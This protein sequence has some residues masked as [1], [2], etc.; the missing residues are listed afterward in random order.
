MLVKKTNTY[1]AGFTL[2]E[3]LV[4]IFIIGILAALLLANFVGVRERTTDAKIK[5]DLRAL[6]TALRL[7]YNDYN[8]YPDVTDVP[9][10]GSETAFTNDDEST[11]YMKQVPAEFSYNVSADGEEFLLYAALDNL[12]DEDVAESRARCCAGSLACPDEAGNY[13]I[14]CED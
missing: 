14:I 12:S 2:I 6:K 3:L 9:A 8:G 1:A 7:Y 5:N 13:Y 4:V 11:V 10:A